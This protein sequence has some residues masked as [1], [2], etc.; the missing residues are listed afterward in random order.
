MVSQY[1]SLY[2]SP[3]LHKRLENLQP[4]TPKNQDILEIP[5]TIL[6]PLHNPSSNLILHIYV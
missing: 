4:S 6:Y 2:T 1:R 3:F 5:G